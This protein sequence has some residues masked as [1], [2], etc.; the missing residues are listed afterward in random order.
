MPGCR[1]LGVH[2]NTAPTNSNRNCP[3]GPGDMAGPRT[4]G[5]S[6]AGAGCPWS[7]PRAG[8]CL[9]ARHAQPRLSSQGTPRAMGAA[10]ARRKVQLPG[11]SRAGAL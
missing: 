6:T 11:E 2:P 7:Q 1:A 9:P 5:F 10:K 8:H 3:S 4:P